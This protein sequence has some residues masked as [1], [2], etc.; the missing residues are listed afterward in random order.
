MN[1][2]A[3]KDADT[4]EECLLHLD[5][6]CQTLAGLNATLVSI[7]TAVRNHDLP[8]LLELVQEKGRNLESVRQARQRRQAFQERIRESLPVAHASLA[9]WAA[10]LEDPARENVLAARQRLLSL[11]KQVRQ[12]AQINQVV[13][14]RSM[15][16]LNR[17]V[18]CLN[19]Q[20]DGSERYSSSGDMVGETAGGS[21]PKQIPGSEVGKSIGEKLPPYQASL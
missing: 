10:L 14:G 3:A 12:Q 5:F 19:G 2:N 11:A 7:D 21:V 20:D 4:I 15:R 18:R 9:E 6:E 17:I 8:Q 16:V 13:V 1:Q